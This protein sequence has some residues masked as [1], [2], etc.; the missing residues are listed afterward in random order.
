MEQ[1]KWSE[2]G[3]GPWW[4]AVQVLSGRQTAAT[5]L[6]IFNHPEN[7]MITSRSSAGAHLLV[8]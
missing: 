1:Q 5:S 3:C 8:Q 7:I 4:S 6:A 2:E